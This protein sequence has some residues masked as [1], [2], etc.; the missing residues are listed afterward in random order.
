M[1]PVCRASWTGL[2]AFRLTPGVTSGR[3]PAG[4]E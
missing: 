4:E 3:H 1:S 2:L